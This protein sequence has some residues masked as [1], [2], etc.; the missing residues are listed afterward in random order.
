MIDYVNG[1][2]DLGDH[3]RAVGD[4]A[5]RFH[6]DKLRLL[7]AIRFA[8]ALAFDIDDETLE[9]VT[10]MAPQVTVC[11]RERIREELHKVLTN[12]GRGRA[13]RLL[14]EA[15]LLKATLPD[16][17]ALGAQAHARAG[18]M[19]DA[20]QTRPRCRWSWATP[21]LDLG[22]AS[23]AEVLTGL[24]C[25]NELIARVQG[26]IADASRMGK[27]DG[28]RVAEK[29]ACCENR[30]SKT[31]SNSARTRHRRFGRHGSRQ[32]RPA[33]SGRAQSRRSLAQSAA[34]RKRSRGHGH[35]AGAGVQAAFERARRRKRL[36]A[37]ARAKRS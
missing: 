24:R 36:K 4:P 29:N 21:S 30:A 12:I 5:V 19:L 18:T 16:V 27:L 13:L 10:R 37:A 15:G 9:A 8:C 33:D 14:I 17:E 11:W 28:L 6:E 35:Q 31:T 7:R 34:Q 26:L 32:A 23:A 2:R 20:R 3:I 25:A 1:V 22:A